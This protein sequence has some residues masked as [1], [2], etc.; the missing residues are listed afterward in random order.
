MQK[1]HPHT[2]L[3]QIRFLKQAKIL[4]A[5][6]DSNRFS[7]CLKWNLLLFYKAI[8]QNIF[9]NFTIFYSIR[10]NFLY[11]YGSKALKSIVHWSS[12][13]EEVKSLIMRHL[14]VMEVPAGISICRNFCKEVFEAERHLRS[15]DYV[16]KVEEGRH[17]WLKT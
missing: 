14:E 17:Q 10:K 3:F 15:I 8:V 16:P 7:L 11:M 4:I 13:K 9:W 1:T 5:F 2:F 12:C 6:L